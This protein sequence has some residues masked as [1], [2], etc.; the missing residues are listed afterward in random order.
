MKSHA[1]HAMEM[2]FNSVNISLKIQFNSNISPCY[3]KKELLKGGFASEWQMPLR[4]DV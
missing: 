3:G 1:V 4:V 2:R